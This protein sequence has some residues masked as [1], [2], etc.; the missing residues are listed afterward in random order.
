MRASSSRTAQCCTIIVEL[1]APLRHAAR[2]RDLG[3]KPIGRFK[4]QALGF[5][6]AQCEIALLFKVERPRHIVADGVVVAA[7]DDRFGGAARQAACA[8][9]GIPRP[10]GYSL[11]NVIDDRFGIAL[12]AGMRGKGARGAAQDRKI[13]LRDL[14]CDAAQF[15][16][17]KIPSSAEC[18]RS[19]SR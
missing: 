8:R 18:D 13:K 14:L 6:I 7:G 3:R 1:F 9:A 4:F 2:L 12:N 5:Q 10:I 17:D 11:E 19:R 16:Q 15:L